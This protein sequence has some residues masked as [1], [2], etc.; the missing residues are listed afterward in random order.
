[1]LFR[2]LAAAATTVQVRDKALQVS[3][4]M[5][6]AIFPEDGM[7]GELLVRQADQAMYAA[8]QAGRN[9]YHFNGQNQMGTQKA[10]ET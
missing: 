5:G 7:E 1:M 9:R 10:C 4:S 3:A 8:K 2:S 6:V